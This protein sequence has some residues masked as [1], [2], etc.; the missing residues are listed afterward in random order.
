VTASKSFSPSNHVVAVLVGA[1][2]A[3][4]LAAVGG[5]I[6]NWPMKYRDLSIKQLNQFV[7]PE[8]WIKP[9]DWAARK[10]A[11][12]RVGVVAAAR[13]RNALKGDALMGAMIVQVAAI[14]LIAAAVVLI[15]TGWW[16]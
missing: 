15:L 10:A 2:S 11:K 9:A 13:H 1:L 6:A 3:F 8:M 5:I 12:A 7:S 14:V 4:A 16:K